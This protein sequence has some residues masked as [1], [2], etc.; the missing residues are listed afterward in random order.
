MNMSF[1][2]SWSRNDKLQFIK[3]YRITEKTKLGKMYHLTEPEI[4]SI[5]K[6]LCSSFVFTEEDIENI[7]IPTEYEETKPNEKYRHRHDSYVH[8]WLLDGDEKELKKAI[9]LYR[10]HNIDF[11]RENCYAVL[12]FRTS[13]VK[14]KDVLDKLN[15]ICKEY[16]IPF[17]SF[18]LLKLDNIENL[19]LLMNNVKNNG[20]G[21]TSR[22]FGIT[23]E[24][25]K[26]LLEHE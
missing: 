14:N 7:K 12:G 3:Q 4:H 21:F 26:E 25:I 23:I 19:A 11:V 16:K 13:D 10:T 6:Y 17:P 15:I 1:L 18:R 8:T 22:R 2:S 24:K 9:E 20:Y 5:Y